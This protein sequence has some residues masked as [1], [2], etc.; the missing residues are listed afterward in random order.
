MWKVVAADDE[1]YIREALKKLIN[2]EKMNC[3]LVSVLED[4]QELIQCI[5]NESPDIV[6]TDIQMPGVN[7]LEVCKYLYETRPETQIIILTA[8]SDFDYAKFAIK[9][10]ACEYV[11]KI[12]IMDELPEALEKATGKLTQLKKE[13]EKEEVAVSEQ[14]TLLQQ[15]D[16]Y[17]EQ[18]FKNK[19]S[20]D[21]IADELHVNRSYLSRFY[22]NKTGINLFD[23]ILNL[24]IEAAKEYLLNT[25][26]KT[27]EISEAIGVD[28]AGY[29]S[30]MFKKI[31]GVSPKEFRK[32]GKMKKTTKQLVT[33]MLILGVGCILE[34][35]GKE[36]NHSVTITL[37]HAW[38][39]TE[40]DH[41]AMREIYEEFQEENP[42]I[43]LQ[44]ISM[45]TR[46][47]MMRKV[48]DMIMVGNIPD[49][50][51]FSGTGENN[52]YD[53]MIE[54]NMALDI[55]PYMQQDQE[56]ADSIS[57][58]NKEYWSTENGELY[59]VAD[60]RMLSG[61]YWYNEDILKAA[62][63]EKVPKSWDEFQTMCD[64]ISEWALNEK[65]E[66]KALQPTAEGYLYC[67]D[68]MLAGSEDS[69]FEGHNLIFQDE[70]FNNA[71][72]RM[73]RMYNSAISENAEYSYRDETHLF[74]EGKLAIYI[75]GVWGAPMISKQIDAKYALLP[76]DG[77]E[78]M[79]CISSGLGYV[80][81]NSGNEEKEKAAVKFLKYMLSKK[82]Q[83]KILEKTEQIPANPD[84]SL[85][86]YK[87]SKSRLY[88]AA[89]LVLETDEKIEVPNNIWSAE[90]KDYFIKTIF[91]VLTGTLS[92]QEFEEGLENK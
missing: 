6:I 86:S 54:N 85:E 64:Q 48:E 87:E 9:Y 19:I 39:G 52:T 42:D 40:E 69:R 30:K 76:T 46:E 83:T 20:L 72:N 49:I 53:F 32:Q 25:D 73:K 24:R 8:Y 71:I 81:G 90:Q 22:K 18:N 45:P 34:G 51:S 70:I 60:A 31:T 56:F 67:M 41:V 68:H 61:G 35:C 63:I 3:D 75:N 44:M 2:W 36:S 84:I 5:E 79:S 21:E 13:I 66:V 58:V 92:I 80:L 37:I 89:T 4:G 27:Y 17:V 23:T 12:S 38:G 77:G 29:F 55:Y 65:N 82:V 10:N 91:D 62:G 57:E 1:G 88:Q 7:G 47:D 78:S 28:D 33:L 14:R 50:V 74:N 11:L 59:S 43:N 26:M 16:Q 15:I